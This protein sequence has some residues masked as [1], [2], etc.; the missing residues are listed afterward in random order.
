MSKPQEQSL[1][2]LH[3]P[4]APSPRSKS[5]DESDRSPPWSEIEINGENFLLSLHSC[6]VVDQD[7]N[8]RLVTLHPPATLHTLAQ[9]LEKIAPAGRAL[10]V[11]YPV[12]SEHLP[13]QRQLLTSAITVQI[14]PHETAESVAQRTGWKLLEKPEYAP[15]LGIFEAANPIDG[16]QQCLDWM[17]SGQFSLIEIQLARQRKP[18]SRTLPN[19]P[20][21]YDQWHLLHQNQP[22]V[23]TGTDVNVIDLWQ[24]GN[25]P[26]GNRGAGIRV[27]VVDD[28]VD[29][30]HEDLAANMDV[31]NDYDWNGRDDLPLPGRNNPHGTACAGIIGAIGNNG[32]GVI[33]VAP[34][35]KLVAMRL[36]GGRS[37]DRTEAAAMTFRQELIPIKS[38]SWGPEDAPNRIEGPGPLTRAALAHAATQGRD[39]KGTI[40]VWSAG[41]G[42]DFGDNCN[43]DGFS[44][45]IYTIAVGAVDSRGRRAYYSEPGA[46]LI[47]CAPSDGFFGTA[48]I[49]TTDRTG[50]QGYSLDDYAWDFGGTSASCP[51]VAGVVALMLERNPSLHWRDVQEILLRS[52]KRLQSTSP[53][54]QVNSAGLAFH[55]D[56]GAGIVDAAAAVEMASS[57]SNLAS[58]VEPIVATDNTI[59]PIPD[60]SP[61]GVVKEFPIT[62]EHR[63]EHVTVTVDLRHTRRGQVSLSLISPS[64]MVS[65][66]APVRSDRRAHWRNWTFSSVRHW[67]E[68]SQGTWKLVFKD[69]TPRTT[70]RLLRVE[71][72]LHGT[73]VSTEN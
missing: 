41:N 10:P 3:E 37:T 61:E 39:G 70:G 54:W 65:E 22:L 44:N 35:S 56:F 23:S 36:I 72:R 51:T 16:L 52:S 27:G 38:N 62:A 47:C 25:E 28:G 40:F 58:A 24:Y 59:T 18:R 45:S 71:L 5:G 12:G 53:Q 4:Q 2:S 34:E 55:P 17:K 26:S 1:G 42:G 32:R 30:Q 48:M 67:G 31:E 50:T 6:S 64:G 49:S 33:G 66:L 13:Q 46:N 60:L 19:D 63:V 11:V 68:S 7:G 73:P 43:F 21:F 9:R 14:P 57:W 69:L 29:L 15:D 8:D 20:L